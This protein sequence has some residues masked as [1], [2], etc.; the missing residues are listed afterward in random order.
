MKALFLLCFPPTVVFS[1]T[2]LTDDTIH[3]AVEDLR[4][5]KDDAVAIYGNIT[6]WN[7]TQVTNMDKLFYFKTYHRSST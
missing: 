3:D 6:K 2:V 4:I 7:T 5:N 1:L